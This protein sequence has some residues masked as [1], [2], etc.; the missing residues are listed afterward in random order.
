MN[1]K[2]LVEFKSS[3][4]KKYLYDSL[5]GY[6]YPNTDRN[7]YNEIMF[8]R[9]N[10]IEE[11]IREKVIVTDR[12]WKN[13]EVLQ[14]MFLSISHNCN[15]KCSY[16]FADEGTYGEASLMNRKTAKDSIDY[17]VK[18][19]S[20]NSKKTNINFFGG[21]P[22]LNK[23]TFFYSIDYINSLIKD[24]RINYIV[25]TNGTIMD[26][27]IIRYIIDND[28]TVIFSIDGIEDSHNI[29][30][31]FKD[32]TN[33]YK[34]IIKNLKKLKKFHDKVFVRMTLTKNNI[35]SFEDSV[36]KFWSKGIK[37]VYFAPVESDNNKLALEYSD[38]VIFEEQLF[39]LVDYANEQLKNGHQYILYN[40]LLNEEKL[41][42]LQPLKECSFFNS[43]TI[44]VT[45]KG[46]IYNCLRIIGDKEMCAGNIYGE[47]YWQNLKREYIP[48]LKCKTCWARKLCS[49]GC[50]IYNRDILCIFYKIIAKAAL[51]SYA[52]VLENTNL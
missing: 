52:G 3:N 12:Q 50:H 5:T 16:C 22:L 11:V 27:D 2:N 39:S 48:D 31:K 35:K 18:Y 51:R 37:E 6:I 15:M 32:D 40:V 24:R 42:D 13:K 7:S 26:D 4:E 10:S 17:F 8:A 36:L 29:N 46:D 9:P 43:F 28:V 25:T 21:E 34:T 41:D 14:N 1:R 38:L 47:L 23:D 20:K 49:G 45:T 44:M 33:T 30:R 19:L